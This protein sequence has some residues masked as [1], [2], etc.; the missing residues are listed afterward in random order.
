MRRDLLGALGTL[1]G[2]PL[3]QCAEARDIGKN[4]RG[5]EAVNAG[6]TDRPRVVGQT[7]QHV[8]RDVSGEAHL[9]AGGHNRPCFEP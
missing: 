7:A 9:R 1:S 5:F 2:Q 3:R 8:R 4:D 6:L